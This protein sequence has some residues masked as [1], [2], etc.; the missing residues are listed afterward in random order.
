MIPTDIVSRKIH[1]QLYQR[2]IDSHETAARHETVRN[3]PLSIIAPVDDIANI[4][5]VVRLIAEPLPQP[6][7]LDG[8]LRLEDFHLVAGTSWGKLGCNRRCAVRYRACS[9]SNENYSFIYLQK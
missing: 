3:V 2:A 4:E 6:G 1:V 8:L 9:T 7:F 5:L